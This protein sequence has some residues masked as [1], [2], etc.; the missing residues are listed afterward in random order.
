MLWI[1]EDSSLIKCNI[2]YCQSLWW[3]SSSENRA[4]SIHIG[5]TW[6]ESCGII[7]LDKTGRRVYNEKE[8]LSSNFTHSNLEWASRN[9]IPKLLANLSTILWEPFMYGWMFLYKSFHFEDPTL[10]YHQSQSFWTLSII[11]FLS[12]QRVVSLWPRSVYCLRT[13]YS[14]VI[15]HLH[16]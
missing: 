6:K 15:K 13:S 10:C 5:Q 11:P 2:T 9:S 12:I 8:G 3:I 14:R 1:L 7:F 4:H 16:C